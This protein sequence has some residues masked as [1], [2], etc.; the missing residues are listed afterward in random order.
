M[1]LGILLRKNVFLD[2]VLILAGVSCLLQENML[3]GKNI[4]Y[5]RFLL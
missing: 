2:I 1:A 3:K 5:G 4:L